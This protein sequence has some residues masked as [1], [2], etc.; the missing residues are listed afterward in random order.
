[1]PYQKRGRVFYPH[2]L[3]AAAGASSEVEQETIRAV[4]VAYAEGRIELE[5][6]KPGSP[7]GGGTKLRVAP[8][9]IPT[10]GFTEAK[11]D[12]KIYNAETVARFLQAS[13]KHGR[14]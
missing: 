13:T 4:V 12:S 3:R 1:M 10:I 2:Y 5:K 8:S 11:T 7:K 6:P 14:W 9:F